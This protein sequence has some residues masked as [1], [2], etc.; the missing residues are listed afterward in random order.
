MSILAVARMKSPGCP[1]MWRTCGEQYPIFGRVHNTSPYA[2][3]ASNVSGTLNTHGQSSRAT[4][5]SRD[6]N[7]DLWVACSGPA[8]APV[9]ASVD[10]LE[11]HQCARGKQSVHRLAADLI[12]ETWRCGK[13]VLWWRR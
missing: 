2:S 8:G 3:E 4:F 9:P 10:D 6:G 1:W 5:H 13:G 11:H 7:S 12:V